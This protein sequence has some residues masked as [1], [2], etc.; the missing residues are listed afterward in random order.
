MSSVYGVESVELD[1]LR[2]MPRSRTSCRK[3]ILDTLEKHP[4]ITSHRLTELL[5]CGLQGCQRTLHRLRHDGDVT[6][7]L[8]HPGEG[9]PQ[10]AFWSVV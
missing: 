2:S 4:G 6:R 9:K 8:Y 3:A 7:R 10:T 1:R 5:G